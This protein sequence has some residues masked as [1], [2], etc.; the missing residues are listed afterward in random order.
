[1]WRNSSSGISGFAFNAPPTPG[2]AFQLV[3]L[4]ARRR[5][6]YNL[7]AGVPGSAQLTRPIVEQADFEHGFF[8]RCDLASEREKLAAP[9]ARSLLPIRTVAEAERT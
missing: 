9:F 5:F 8:L 3:G 4:L 6:S 2:K 1:M 7:P